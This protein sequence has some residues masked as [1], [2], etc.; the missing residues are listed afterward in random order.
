MK[1]KLELVQPG[2]YQ[3]VLKKKVARAQW[4]AIAVLAVVALVGILRFIIPR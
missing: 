1:R 4:I 3:E 2:A